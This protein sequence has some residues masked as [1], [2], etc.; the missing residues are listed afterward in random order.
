MK[1]CLLLPLILQFL[2]YSHSK[3][4]NNIL[5][6]YIKTLLFFLGY[7]IGFSYIQ[8]QYIWQIFN[9]SSILWQIIVLLATT[10]PLIVGA[11][12]FYWWVNDYNEN[13][14]TRNLKKFANSNADW[15][16]VASDINTEFR[17]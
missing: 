13:P 8:N 11:T 15:K 9:D 5:L 17:R 4:Y 16:S 3:I 1:N 6:K 10:A 12:A 14:T 2:D 7:L